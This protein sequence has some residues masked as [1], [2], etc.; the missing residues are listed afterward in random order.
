MKITITELKRLIKET[1][2]EVMASEDDSSGI[3]DDL[4]RS[5][6][7]VVKISWINT[8]KATPEEVVANL[9]ELE[10]FREEEFSHPYLVKVAKKFLAP[11]QK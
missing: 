2:E 11:Y 10:P 1:I 8:K 6:D 3:E 5:I 9:V 4:L 7:H